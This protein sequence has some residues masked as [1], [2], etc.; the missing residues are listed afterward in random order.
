MS[1]DKIV[2]K[3]ILLPFILITSCFSLWGFANDITNPMVEAFSRIF[4][5][6]VSGG[7]WVQVVFYGGYGAMAFPAALFIKRFSYKAGILLGL[8]LYAAGALLFIPASGIGLYPPFLIAY[9]IM[10]CGLSFLETSANP[11]ILSMGSEETAT[12][13]LNLAQAFNP[14]GSLSGMFVATVF[15]Q[16]RLD[17]RSA[18]ER[19]LLSPEDFEKLKLSDLNILSSP[20]ITIGFVLILMFILIAIVKMPKKAEEDH[21]MNLFSTISRLL[22]I[23]RYREGVLAQTFYVGAQIMCWTFIVQYGQRVFMNQ[24]IEPQALER[25]WLSFMNSLGFLNKDT[26]SLIATGKAALTINAGDA[27]HVAQLYNILAMLIFLISRFVCTFLLKY[28]N[29]GA[30]LMVLSFG[31]IALSAGTILLNGMSGLYCLIGISACMSLMFPTIYGISLKGMG[32]DAK[33]GA[34]GLIMAIVGGTFLPKI[35]AAIIDLG[36]VASLPAVNASFI[37][38]LFCFAIIAT[39]GYRTKKVFFK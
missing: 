2:S 7:T 39:F 26:A 6:D 16:A 4:K 33:F 30:L 11:Y 35:Q 25:G 19:S 3:E 21:S 23:K 32:N 38:P 5:M 14:I 8:G 1:K 31:G 18:S 9:F 13:R 10:T 20:Y 24:G 34:A 28:I 36:S 27:A 22:K 29:S 12:Q 37:L 15:I 17:K